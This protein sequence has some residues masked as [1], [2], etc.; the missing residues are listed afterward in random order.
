MHL[1][2]LES[3]FLKTKILLADDHRLL[4][5]GLTRLFEG[6]PNLEV[7]G[8]A[9]SG[10]EAVELAGKLSPDLILLDISM[11][12]LNGID[13]IRRILETQPQTKILM[14]SMHSDRRFINEALKLGA[15]GYLLKDAAFQEVGEAI[16]AVLNDEIFL[17]QAVRDVVLGD[18]IRRLQ[19]TESSA[20]SN[21]SGREREVLQLIAEGKGTKDIAAILHVSV[22]T[23]ESH[24]K[25][26]MDKLGLHSIAELTKYAIREGLTQLE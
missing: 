20:F 24:R 15:K 11:P 3:K 18:Y 12:D 4:L 23:I 2:N 13:C 9:T 19:N 5:D 1:I 6:S 8:V 17:S 14:L 21:L 7:V 22:K 16:R 25:Q 26:I 10:L